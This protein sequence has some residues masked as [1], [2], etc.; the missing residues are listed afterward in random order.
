MAGMAT[1]FLDP[2][3]KLK[4]KIKNVKKDTFTPA[5]ASLIGGILKD[6]AVS[7]GQVANELLSNPFTGGAAAV[8]TNAL[9]GK[10]AL[11]RLVGRVNED[12]G[13][14]MRGEVTPMDVANV[15]SII[16]IPAGGI[17]RGGLLGLKAGTKLLP[18][19]VKGGKYAAETN[20]PL[21]PSLLARGVESLAYSPFTEGI[22][23]GIINS[24]GAVSIA[25]DDNLDLKTKIGLITGMTAA[26]MLPGAYGGFKKSTAI[27]NAVSE[28]K[29]NIAGGKGTASDYVISNTSKV[30]SSESDIT[31]AMDT[32]M[33]YPA[34]AAFTQGTA[35]KDLKHNIRLY[36]N[37]SEV[38]SIVDDVSSG[39]ITPDEGAKLL[40]AFNDS[41]QV[42]GKVLGPYTK[43]FKSIEKY[44]KTGSLASRGTNKIQSLGGIRQP[45]KLDRFLGALNLNP[46]VGNV[47]DT[48]DLR[49]WAALVSEGKI[50]TNLD[51]NF[52]NEVTAGPDASM[53]NQER[54]REAMFELE[55]WVADTYKITSP[56]R[57]A[58][59]RERMYQGIGHAG[60]GLS[61]NIF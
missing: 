51:K 15:A 3:V 22:G 13:E 10:D 44:N 53:I 41:Q 16:P 35:G 9:F 47:G 34:I 50:S 56:A 1:G 40:K 37:N 33:P 12:A 48:R 8:A 11:S 23:E 25:G 59:V 24:P 60:E 55:K 49:L 19:A 43:I 2:N 46:V 42:G 45:S 39:T 14:S 27:K 58:A 32:D 6:T 30:P 7:T 18:R 20:I 54:A 61:K 21:K 36:E 52:L 17:V 29:K 38:K 5:V 4:Y 28:A 26:T 57:Q 31:L